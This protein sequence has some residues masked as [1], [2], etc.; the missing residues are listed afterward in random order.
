MQG[1]TLRMSTLVQVCSGVGSD[2]MQGMDATWLDH[3]HLFI[4][5]ALD[6]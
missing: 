6:F 5:V 3:P 2:N 4:I 1:Q